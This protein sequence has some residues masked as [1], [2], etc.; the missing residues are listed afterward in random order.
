MKGLMD[1][2]TATSCISK[3]V[4]HTQLLSQEDPTLW[5]Y[6]WKMK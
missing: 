1:S 3:E 5:C 2:T 6:C 4:V